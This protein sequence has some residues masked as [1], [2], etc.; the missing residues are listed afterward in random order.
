MNILVFNCGSS[1]LKYRLLD[2]PKGVERAGGEA[3]RVG[4]PTAKP[5]VIFHHARGKKESFETPMRSHGE[6]FVEVMKL[7]H[8]DADLTPGAVGHRLV[9]G[10]TLFSE[11]TVVDA[12]VLSRLEQVRDMAPLHNPPAMA[13]MQACHERFPDL[14]QVAVFD[15]AFH[16]TIPAHART[17]A[18][19]LRLRQELGIRKY[20]FH[21]TSHQFVMEEAAAFLGTPLEL[22]NAVSCHLGSGGASLCAI[23]NGQSVDN[24]MG[25]SPLQGLVMSTRCGDLDPAL[26][27]NLLTRAGGD[28]AQVEKL[29]NNRSG[30]LGMSGS[31]AD[32]RDVLASTSQ[33]ETW[34][35]RLDHTAQVYLWRLRKYLGAYLAV[36]GNARAVIFTDTIGETVPAVRWGLCSGMEAFGLKMDAGLNA[37]VAS[38]PAD[39]AADDSRIRILVVQT[40]EELAIARRTYGALQTQVVKAED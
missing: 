20:G 36:V 32:I 3:Q 10:G 27:M 34:T 40:N 7:L 8:R 13:L 12:N 23:R 5:S 15:T 18:L 29:L 35:V 37:K 4:P 1:S 16:A 31:T 14:P 30:V 6:A 9:H 25:Y 2:M 39:V 21:G 19:P 17:Y 11:P 26:A 24:T 22:F 38:L 33:T 28:C